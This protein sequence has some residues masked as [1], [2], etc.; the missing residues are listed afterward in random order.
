MEEVCSSETLVL[1]YQTTRYHTPEDHNIN[2]HFWENI[3]YRTFSYC[4][5]HLWLK[6]QDSSVGIA[7]SYGLDCKGSILA[8]S[9]VFLFS[10]KSRLASL[11]TQPPMQRVPRIVSPGL[12]RSGFEAGNSPPFNSEDKNC[13]AIPSLSRTWNNFIFF[14]CGTAVTVFTH[15]RNVTKYCIAYL[16]G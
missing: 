14:T 16:N 7:T 5:S 1:T 12:K 8:K 4:G 6:S 15:F 9:K 10:I 3:K 11:R 2:F 13:G